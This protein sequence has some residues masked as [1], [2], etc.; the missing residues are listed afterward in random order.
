MIARCLEVAGAKYIRDP[1]QST[2]PMESGAAWPRA[3]SKA[4]RRSPRIGLL[5]IIGAARAVILKFKA[6]ISQG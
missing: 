6:A 5:S 1:D 4:S 3:F 2:E